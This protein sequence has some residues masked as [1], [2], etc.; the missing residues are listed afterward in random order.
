MRWFLILLIL[1][2]FPSGLFDPHPVP[3]V[4]N[5]CRNVL[6]TIK[7]QSHFSNGIWRNGADVGYDWLFSAVARG[8][9]KLMRWHFKSSQHRWGDDV[10]GIVVSTSMPC[11][12]PPG[13]PPREKRPNGGKVQAVCASGVERSKKRCRIKDQIP[14]P[15][16]L[17]MNWPMMISGIKTPKAMVGKMM[18]SNAIPAKL[19]RIRNLY[20]L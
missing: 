10:M 3:T 4:G 17:A 9:D 2:P 13:V 6:I 8:A 11:K 5:V 14:P 16:T 20:F 19:E 1:L 18:E 7:A 15:A 12:N